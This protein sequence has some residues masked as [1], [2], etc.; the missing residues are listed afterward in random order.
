MKYITM[1]LQHVKAKGGG[2]ALRPLA[3]LESSKKR[4]KENN[5]D[6]NK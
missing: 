1:V 6:Y 3:V 5:S 4:K 2:S